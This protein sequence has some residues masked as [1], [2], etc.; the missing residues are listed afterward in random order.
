MKTNLLDIAISF[1]F[2]RSK[3]ALNIELINSN[4][5]EFSELES[6]KIIVLA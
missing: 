2:I 6:A 4:R 3:L 1:F 5:F